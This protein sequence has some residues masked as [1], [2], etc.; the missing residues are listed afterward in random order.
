MWIEGITFFLI[1]LLYM[2]CVE[3]GQILT[4]LYR[5]QYWFLRLFLSYSS[6]G[7]VLAIHCLSFL[8]SYVTRN[9]ISERELIRHAVCGQGNMQTKAYSSDWNV[10]S[11]LQAMEFILGN[12]GHYH[13]D[14]D[15]FS[16]IR[17]TWNTHSL[18]GRP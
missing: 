13:M 4:L 6:D 16:V 9:N 2:Y 18:Q 14:L 1:T 12:Q 8:V 15:L 5:W 3:G 10:T 7:L 11:Q 17:L